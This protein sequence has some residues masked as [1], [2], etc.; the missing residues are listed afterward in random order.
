M[1]KSG[2][3]ANNGVR[4]LKFGLFDSGDNGEHNGVSLVE[5][6]KIFVTQHNFFFGTDRF[7]GVKI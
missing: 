2:N 6:S 7:D 1:H 3:S 5:I 4:R